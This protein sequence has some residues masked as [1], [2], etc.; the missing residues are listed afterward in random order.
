MPFVIPGGEF[1]HYTSFGGL[2]GIVHSR[3]IWATSVH[4][5]NDE[6]EFR[7]G[8]DVV[9]RHI[10]G[11]LHESGTNHE[12]HSRLSERFRGA[13]RLEVYVFSFSEVPD[14][15]SQWRAYCP[16]GAG[17]AI[18]FPKSLIDQRAA[19]HGFDFV[20]CI[21][22]P[23]QQA[24]AVATMLLEA[25]TAWEN[26]GRTASELDIQTERLLRL[27]PRMK[28][29]SFRE[30]KEWRLV[31]RPL[32]DFGDRLDYRATRSM[33]LPYVRVG[34]AEAGQEITLGNI[35]VGPNRHIESAMLA[36][37]SLLRSRP[38]IKHMCVERS[39]VPYRTW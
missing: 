30:E 31:S 6:Q 3:E 26:S 4:Y 9:L 10:E 19:V 32:I 28:H 7:H 13:S 8:L 38:R 18:G 12:L 14:L 21:Y 24:E 20:P 29:H 39:Q 33:L 15:L 1:Y 27:V 11:W 16:D 35:F 17:V 22:D 2:I 34:L 37:G 36:V 5:L 25:G 23:L